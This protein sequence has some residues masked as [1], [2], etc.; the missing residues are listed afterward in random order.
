M[1]IR[2][3]L[4][5]CTVLICLVL[6]PIAAQA[7]NPHFSAIYVFGD[8]YCDAGNLF[9][10]DGGT[11]PISPP[12]FHGHFSNGLVWAEHVAGSWGLPLTPSLAGG[13][14]YAW[15]G[16]FVTADQPLYAIEADTVAQ[17]LDQRQAASPAMSWD[18]TLGNMRTLDRWRES[19]GLVYESE[20]PGQIATLY[21]TPLTVAANASMPYGTIPHLDKKV[22][23]L[24]MGCDN[25][26]NL[27][28]A[29]LM[30][31]DFFARGGNAFDTAYIYGGG[32]HEKLLGQWIK[33]RGVREKRTMPFD[34]SLDTHAPTVGPDRFQTGSDRWPGHWVRFPHA[35]VDTPERNLLAAEAFALVRAAMSELPEQQRVV[36]ALRDV[37][38]YESSEVCALLGLTMAN[39]RVLLHRGRAR[40]REALVGYYE[41]VS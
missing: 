41:A 33:T 37:E 9:L 4:L 31:D 35:W 15:G 39:Q 13:T 2:Q 11:I 38:G 1:S 5:L 26:P 6:S 32:L 17:Y 36:V 20:K 21:A 34:A 18:D 10:A 30:F 24:V 27:P 22:S 8:S 28:H 29:A 7:A 16:A 3:A 25:Q 23:R 40:I 19:I 12:Y 14:D